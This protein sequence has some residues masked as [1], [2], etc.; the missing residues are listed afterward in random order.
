MK[1]DKLHTPIKLK[2]LRQR[3][4]DHEKNS[5]G[6]YFNETNHRYYDQRTEETVINIFS[7]NCYVTDQPGEVVVTILGSCI[8][9]CMRD[10]IAHV[11]GMNHFLLPASG[12]IDEGNSFRFG[13]FAM[14]Q[15]I[16]ELMKR[17]AQKERL[18][19]K[20]FGGGNVLQNN[21]KDPV[22]DRNIAFVREFLHKEGLEIAAEDLGGNYPRRVHY[23][24]DS[25]RVLLR[26]LRR[27]EDSIIIDKEKQYIKKLQQNNAEYSDV[28][29]F[30]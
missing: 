28:E 9:A 1:E 18:E 6:D 14:E 8:A 13:L 20:L 3:R 22:G 24:T 4:T 11:G 2:N 5:V 15:L 26:K 21:S 16:N 12:D 30:E 10:P 29:L 25:G 7:G 19:I 27:E 17:G 23:Y